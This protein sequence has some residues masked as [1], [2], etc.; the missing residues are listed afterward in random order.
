M[1]FKFI[2]SPINAGAVAMI[3]GMI[4]VPIV[5]LIS[6]KMDKVKIDEIF[7]CLEEKV[8]VSKR[9]SIEE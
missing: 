8:L 1:F 9:K 7:I 5:S 2:A 3:A 6:P 4:I